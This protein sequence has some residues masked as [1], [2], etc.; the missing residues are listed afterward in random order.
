M[1]GDA[2]AS[3]KPAYSAPAL[4]KGLDVLE[5]L[6]EARSPLTMKEIAEGLGRS[7]NEIFRMLVALQDRAYI[8]RDPQTDAYSLT[9]RLFK[10]GLHSPTAQ[11]LMSASM[12]ELATVARECQHSPHLVLFNRGLTVVTAAVP[13]GEDMSFTLRLGYGLLASR[14]TSG[15]VIL[16]FQK[17]EVAQRMIDQCAARSPEPIDRVELEERLN[18]IRASGYVLRDSWDFVGLTDICCPVLGPDGSAVASIII[19]Y[20]NRYTRESR[21]AHALEVLRAACDRIS[22]KLSPRIRFQQENRP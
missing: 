15:R 7:K 6:A 21:H 16:A 3:G 22:A 19:A 12:P 11:D 4:T 2:K 9:D 20:L 10:L 5:L 18:V 8:E 17:P 1:S 14:A 13:G